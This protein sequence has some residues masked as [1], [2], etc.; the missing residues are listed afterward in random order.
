MGRVL[1]GLDT[2]VQGARV[3]A[4]SAAGSNCHSSDRDFG[5]VN[6]GPD[7]SFEMGLSAHECQ[8]SVCVFVFARPPLNASGLNSSDT[9]LLV[10]DCRAEGALDSAEVELVLRNIPDAE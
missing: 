2:P 1:G 3:H 4:Y 5:G 10:M 6:T 7:G 8:D 9:A